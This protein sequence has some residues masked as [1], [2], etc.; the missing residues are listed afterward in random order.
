MLRFWAD[1]KASRVSALCFCVTIA[2]GVTFAVNAAA[3]TVFLGSSPSRPG[4]AGFTMSVHMEP[5]GGNGYQPVYLDVTPLGQRFTRDRYLQV[6]IG[7]RHDFGSELDFDLY[8]PVKLPQGATRHRVPVYIPNYFPWD[9]LSVRIIEDGREIESSSMRFGL[10]GLRTRY[11]KQR[12][13]VGIIRPSD[14]AIQDA[15]WKI[16]P[17][18]RT[19]VTVFGDGPLPEDAQVK[20]LPH[21][22]AMSKAEQV[23]PAWVQFRTIEEAALHDNWLGY[24]QLDVILAAD[25]VLRRIEEKSPKQYSAITDWVAAGGNL[26]VYAAANPESSLAKG[27]GFQI[28]SPKEFVSGNKMPNMLQLGVVNDTS[29]LIYEN[30]NGVMKGSQNYSTRSTNNGMTNRGTIFNRLKKSKHPFAAVVPQAEIAQQLRFGKFGDGRVITIA[31]DDPFPG[32][33]QF[34]QSINMIQRDKTL[35]WSQRNGIDV[36]AG[37]DNY[38]LWL[39]R[40]VGQPP[41]KSFVL[42]N[43]LFV[44]IVGP[45]CYFLFRRHGRLYLLYFFAPALALLVTLSLFAYALASDG[46]KTKTRV[47]HITWLDMQNDVALEQSRQTYYAVFG[48]GDGLQFPR[49]SAVYPVR[50]SPATNRYYGRRRSSSRDREIVLRSNVQQF[51][52]GFLP[53]RNQVQYLVNQPRQIERSLEFEWT[54]G[55]EKITNH[56]DYG[57]KRLLVRDQRSQ[58]WSVDD[59]PPGATLSLQSAGIDDVS[60]LLDERVLPVL[61]EVPMLNRNRQYGNNQAPGMQL[62]RLENKLQDWSRGLPRNSFVATAELDDDQLGVEGGVPVDSV[63]VLMGELP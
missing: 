10:N 2:V 56:L 29:S 28:R 31:A 55:S 41:V 7:P 15:A 35:E 43:T 8:C 62:S 53:P 40:S 30:W 25:P 21:G 54:P 6:V 61:G 60:V 51:G 20:R 27:G 50:N 3:E 19:L 45:F 46:T 14:H 36:G 26:W 5:V 63:H 59:L 37:N 4:K 34:W 39:I 12:T 52:G 11:A 48:S 22:K 17:D 13:S 23:Q 16:F 32:S 38:W 57:I 49:D 33:F 24:S 9:N 18:V 42:L 47:R 58:L 44:I 1:Q